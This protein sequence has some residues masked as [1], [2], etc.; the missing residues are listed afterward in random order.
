[1]TSSSE[2]STLESLPVP[3][4]AV[5]S[6][7]PETSGMTFLDHLE[8][9]RKRII[10]S[11]SALIVFIIGAFF[12]AIPV[13]NGLKAVAP[14]TAHFVQLS[15]GE[16]L[17]ASCRISVILGIAFSLPIILYQLLRFV[18]P[19]LKSKEQRYLL[20][21]VMCGA[22]LFLL[23]AVFAYYAVLP[24]T[25][26]WLVDY[27]RDVAETQM[28]IEKFVE[29]ST[30]LI[31]LTGLM[32]ELPMVLFM[33]S[34]TGLIT[35]QKLI[36]QW[37]WATVTIFVVAAIITPSQD[38]LSMTLVGLAMVLLYLISIIPIKLVGR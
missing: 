15:P 17:M 4:P 33:L 8:E 25:L 28:S 31:L 29:F 9:L 34:F 18:V 35:S 5:A 27:G 24:P 6:N 7:T 26:E 14:H 36:A 38:P 3:A 10:I 12:L 20:W 32:F 16:V 37:R 13:M 21:V 19:G 23:G 11:V 30:A 22:F 2:S 1:M